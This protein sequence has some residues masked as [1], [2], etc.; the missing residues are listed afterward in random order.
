[1]RR[2]CAE[3]GVATPARAEAPHPTHTPAHHAPPIPPHPQNHVHRPLVDSQD[4]LSI[5]ADL[6]KLRC[7]VLLFSRSYELQ[8]AN[9]AALRALRAGASGAP[10]GAEAGAQPLGGVLVGEDIASVERVGAC[11]GSP[12]PQEM[13]PART[14]CM[15]DM[16][17]THRIPHH[18]HVWMQKPATS[19]P[20]WTQ[21]QLAAQRSPASPCHH[22]SQCAWRPAGWL[23]RLWRRPPPPQSP[24]AARHC[25]CPCVQRTGSVCPA[26]RSSH[27]SFRRMVRCRLWMQAV[28]PRVVAPAPMCKI[29]CIKA[30]TVPYSARRRRGMCGRV[31][32]V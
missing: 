12:S 26:K 20:P 9:R 10:A 16:H 8:Y 24:A 4:L 2:A 25:A 1:M 23:R 19:T 21:F 28:S 30:H 7:C 22:V 29:A 6:D 18:L 3:V 13:R 27:A 5:D 11:L 17:A 15:H 31:G 32:A 14:A